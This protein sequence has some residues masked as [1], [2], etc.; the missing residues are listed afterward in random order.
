MLVTQ[1][2]MAAHHII[3]NSCCVVRDRPCHEEVFFQTRVTKGTMEDETENQNVAFLK[4]SI[5]SVRAFSEKRVVR[6]E[7]SPGYT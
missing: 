1:L 6:P 3:W 5:H 7:E 4:T 2:A